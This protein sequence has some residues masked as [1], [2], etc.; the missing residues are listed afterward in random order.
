ADTRMT[1]TDTTVLERLFREARSYR[2]TANV[3]DYA[4]DRVAFVRDGVVGLPERVVAGIDV[5]RA[6]RT[7]RALR[8]A[9]TWPGLEHA[10]VLAWRLLEGSGRRQGRLPTRWC[11]GGCS[12]RRGATARRPS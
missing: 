8:Q 7:A 12:A 5:G 6:A 1:A 9:P 10:I 2:E 3:V 4:V 11:W